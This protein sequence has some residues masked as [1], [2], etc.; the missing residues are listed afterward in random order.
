MNL[1]NHRE[2]HKQGRQIRTEIIEA[3]SQHDVLSTQQLALHVDQGVGLV[4]NQLLWLRVRDAIERVTYVSDDYTV[5]GRLLY[6]NVYWSMTNH[7]RHH[8]RKSFSDC[9]GCLVREMEEKAVGRVSLR[10]RI[11]RE[12]HGS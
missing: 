1:I 6:W 7:A 2:V 10:K 3:L 12:L 5:P 9:R 4:A 11:I 8:L